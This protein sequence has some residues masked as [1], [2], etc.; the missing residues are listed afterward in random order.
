MA[1][2]ILSHISE[3]F[4]TWTINLSREHAERDRFAYIAASKDI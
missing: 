3:D 2:M 4:Q 1:D